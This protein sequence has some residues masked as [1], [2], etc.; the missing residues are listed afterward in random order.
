M[1]TFEPGVHSFS[2]YFELGLRHIADFEGYDHMLFLLALV[3]LYQLYDALKVL[4]LVTAFTLGHSLT[5]FLATVDV[6]R[7]NED[8]V[9]FL[10]P[11]TILI[12]AVLNIARARQRARGSMA[13]H[14]SLAAFFGLIHGMGFSN[15]L[16]MLLSGEGEL[17]VPLLA[18]NLGIEVGQ[19]AIVVAIFLLHALA[20]RL[21]RFKQA[22]YILVV[23]GATAGM[24]LILAAEA[25]FW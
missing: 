14:Y 22:D 16:R 3:C 21:F 7:I 19:I 20:F 25:V 8:L 17:F 13:L 2:T 24:A 10:I 4:I 6:I 5:L 1:R 12:T 9:E 23:S 15:H 11:V 18:F